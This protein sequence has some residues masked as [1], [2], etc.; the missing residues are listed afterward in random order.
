MRSLAPF[1]ADRGWE[2]TVYCRPGSVRGDDP[3]RHPLVKVVQTRGVETKSLSTLSYGLSS[4]LDAASKHPDVA[5]VMNVANGFWLPLL[6]RRGIPTLV[7]VDGVEWERDK[8]GVLAKTLFRW[9]AKWTARY[10]TRLVFDSKEIAR[11]WHEE[12]NRDGDFIPYGGTSIDEPLPVHEG[13]RHRSYVLLVAR[14]VPE[15]TIAEFFEA[16]PLLAEHID[17]VIV[18]SSGYEGVLDVQARRLAQTY[19][20]VHWLGHVSD[21]RKLFSLWQH[22][23][24]YFHGHSVGGTNPAL[25]QAM[26][27]GVP[28]IARES[29]Y[30]REVLPSSTTFVAP[31][32]RAIAAAILNLAADGT[33]LES[34]SRANLARAKSDYTWGSVNESYRSALTT[35]AA[36]HST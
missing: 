36:Q 22:A 29:P 13:L 12:F 17:V 18:G 32:P 3:S 6:R 11:R 28:V 1:L 30:N 31:M 9:G 27:L 5:L 24:V 23:A 4:T 21:D 14:F 33:A 34:A 7:N 35:L 19:A 26:S 25:V 15:N 2:V 16:V 20:R 8:W 10:A